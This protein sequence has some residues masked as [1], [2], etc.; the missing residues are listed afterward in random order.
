MVK[1]ID[2]RSGFG[3]YLSLGIEHCK[4]KQCKMTVTTNDKVCIINTP[5]VHF[6][7]NKDVY[8]GGIR[9]LHALAAL[10]RRLSV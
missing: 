9:P 1:E 6:H 4:I 2:Q 7:I 5:G 8:E 10:N 3:I